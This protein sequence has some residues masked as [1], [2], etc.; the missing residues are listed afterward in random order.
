MIKAIGRVF[1]IVSLAM[2]ALVAGA[3]S[4]TTAFNYQG[5]LTDGGN[6]ANGSFQM[7][8]KLFDSA[9]AG[10]QTGSTISDVAVNVTN[11][12]F[13][14]KL[15]FGAP[16]FG[17]ANRWLEI[18]VRHNSSESYVTLSPREQIA[19]SPY[20]I[21]TLNATMADDSQKLGGLPA[22]EYVNASTVNS[23]F[24]RNGTAQQ[25]ANMA[26]SGNAFIAGQIALGVGTFD[27]NFRLNTFGPIRSFSQSAAHF[28]AETNGGDNTWARFY[29]RSPSRSW[30]MGTSQNFNGNQFY[31][32]DESAPGGGANRMAISTD[33]YFGLNNTNPQSGLDI[34]GTGFQ[35]QQRITDNTSGNSLVL[36]GGSG[37]NMKVTGFNFASGTP[38]PLYLSVE[39]ANTLVGGNVAQARGGYGVPKAMLY[40]DNFGTILRCYNGITGSSTGNCG[41]SV[42]ETVAG[43]YTIDF[44]FQVSDKFFYLTAGSE[45]RVAIWRSDCSGCSANQLLVNLS[46]TAGV[47]ARSRFM[48]IVF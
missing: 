40:V 18:A 27:P 22:S 11:G 12:T 26:I 21:R 34:R 6:P 8:F 37:V 15:D 20:A 24:I 28:V 42:S 31:L 19:S 13:S 48:A 3:N 35:V 5:Q 23:Q 46:N 38:V 39:G 1:S 4:Q 10:S 16:A 9:A 41:F 45:D 36:Q 17:G 47:T 14:T 43:V 32:V 2:L 29:M 7:Q 44:G 30:F 33:G 25:T